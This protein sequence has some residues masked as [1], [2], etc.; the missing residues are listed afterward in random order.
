MA[1]IVLKNP[2]RGLGFTANVA[3]AV[4]FRNSKAS[5]SV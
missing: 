4:A 1:K 5:L 2:G 3:S